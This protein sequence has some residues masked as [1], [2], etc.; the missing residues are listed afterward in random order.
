MDNKL[1]LVYLL[2]TSE[3]REY[4]KLIGDEKILE[5]KNPYSG[6]ENVEFQEGFVKIRI[7]N[8]ANFHDLELAIYQGDFEISDL[9]Q[10]TFRTNGL[11]EVGCDGFLLEYVDRIRV[12]WP[13]GI[14]DVLVL[15][16]VLEIV[17]GNIRTVSIY[18]QHIKSRSWLRKIIIRFKN[19]LSK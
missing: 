15:L 9:P 12:P 8:Q 14:T 19:N 10:G 13:E 17:E 3:R 18:L 5:A 1:K 11:I 6:F 4:I 2:S 7:A 16:D